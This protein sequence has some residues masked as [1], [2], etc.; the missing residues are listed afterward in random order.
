MPAGEL[1]RRGLRY[2]MTDELDF[3]E[4]RQRRKERSRTDARFLR[5]TDTSR[6]LKRLLWQELALS[7]LIGGWI[8]A[9]PAYDRKMRLGRQCYLHNRN[10]KCLYER[11]E[12][13]PGGMNDNEWMPDL[14]RETF[15]RMF[16]AAD[17]HAFMVSYLF[18]VR[19]LYAQ[20]DALMA[21][22]DPILNAPTVDQLRFIDVEREATLAWSR[23]Q[24]FAAY[25]SGGE[26]APTTLPPRLAP[27]SLAAWPS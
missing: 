19:Q 14:T 26:G 3:E 27:H 4:L 24:A 12:E 18:A 13:L 11:I 5:P 16:G 2:A 10:A 9:I 8:P 15:E 6:E 1:G 7:K 20:Y 21:K 23:E 25:A 22:L 17:E